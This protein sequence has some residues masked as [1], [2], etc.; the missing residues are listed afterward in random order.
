MILDKARAMNGYLRSEIRPFHDDLFLQ[1][2]ITRE[3]ELRGIRTFI[4]TGTFRGD[5][6]SWFAKRF[7]EVKCVSIESSAGFH[8]LTSIRLWELPHV[9]MMKGDS[10]K[11]LP[12]IISLADQPILFWLDAHWGSD[13][14]LRAELRC[15]KELAPKGIVLIDDIGS[16]PHQGQ[17]IDLELIRE[18]G[19]DPV[20][21][22][23]I[24]AEIDLGR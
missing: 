10:A 12:Y 6:L 11:L 3:V 5:S 22:T 1:Y 14:P 20:M 23:E 7:P 17:K 24:V 18:E 19:F 4:E 15:I 13:L 21:A 8:F 2:R 16:E 9:R